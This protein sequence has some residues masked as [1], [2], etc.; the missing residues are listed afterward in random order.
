MRKRL[1]LVLAAIFILASA[2]IGFA[3]FKTPVK[4]GEVIDLSLFIGDNYPGWW[5][6]NNTIPKITANFNPWSGYVGPYWTQTHIFDSHTATHYDSPRHFIPTPGFDNNTYGD[7]VKGVLKEYESKYGPRSFST[8]CNHKVPVTQMVGPLRVVDVTHL[9]GTVPKDKWATFGGP[10]I[11]IADIQKHEAKYGPIK[12][13]EI[14]AFMSKWDKKYLPFP[15]GNA[16]AP[17]PL[18]FKSEG[19]PTPTPETVFYLQEKGVEFLG[20][21]APSMGDVT[22]RRAIMTHWAGLGREMIFL[23]CMANLDKVPA[24]GSAFLAWLPL[25]IEGASGAIGRAIAFVGPNA[26]PLIASALA[27]KV[28]DMTTLLSPNYP[29][30]WPGHFPIKITQTHIWGP[31]FPYNT[32]FTILD[33]HT[34]THHDTPMHF[35]TPPGFKVTDY[36]PA[37][38]PIAKAYEAKWGPIPHSTMSNEKVPMEYFQGPLKVVDVGL[39]E[40]T[41]GPG[42]KPSIK[43]DAVKAFEAKYGPLQAGDVVLLR[44]GYDDKYYKPF[45]E[46]NRCVPDVQNG[47]AEGWPAPSAELVDYLAKKGI[48]NMVGDFPSMGGQDWYDAHV[49]G[50]GQGMVYVEM[51]MNT[52]DLPNTGAF[53][54][55]GAPKTYGSGQAGRAF[56]ILP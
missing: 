55:Y 15:A 19:W 29:C 26:K 27:G 44:T 8:T 16:Y 28:V 22:G 36:L 51:V 3:D 4:K 45:P 20:I 25:K 7:Y 41:A 17:D 52:G 11:T 14:V 46:G 40:G 34:G 37:Y 48:K 39:M 47:I 9:L 10:E 54:I 42:K 35:V 12:T 33:E 56:A 18:N 31:N 5:P 23:E 21:D 1:I 13:G 2:T 49:V 32:E 24:D 50:L 43:V 6:A 30:S 38:Q 53:F